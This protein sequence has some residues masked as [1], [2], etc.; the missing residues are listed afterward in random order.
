MN[1][2]HRI[3][4]LTAAAEAVQE[5]LHA[6]PA[7]IRAAVILHSMDLPA[8]AQATCYQEL[9]EEC[10]QLDRLRDQAIDAITTAGEGAGPEPY[11]GG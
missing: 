11:S 8:A 5:R 2:A 1:T 9:L 10:K 4:E 6:L 7:P 3:A